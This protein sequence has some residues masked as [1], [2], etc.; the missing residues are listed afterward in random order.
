M[1][2][3]SINSPIIVFLDKFGSIMLINLL[4]ILF[5]LP[6][7]SIGAS[8]TAM[9]RC[10]LNLANG[11]DNGLIKQF[12]NAFRG[13]F[14][15]ST[16]L[17]LWLLPLM[18]LVVFEALILLAGAV[19][20]S[21]INTILFIA[22]FIFAICVISY[23]FPLQAQFENKVFSTVKNAA[24]LAVN[25]FPVTLAVAALNLVFPV[26]LYFFPSLFVKTLLAWILFGFSLIAYINTFLLRKVFIQYFPS[27]DEEGHTV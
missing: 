6:L 9:Y 21:I 17:F 7:I 10:L 23:V 12:W 4:F 13:N 14:K 3:F 25:H 11:N 8:V 19:E 16:L 1:K 2:L 24:L 20:N 27:C 15:Q 22:P 18:A 26:M 5:S